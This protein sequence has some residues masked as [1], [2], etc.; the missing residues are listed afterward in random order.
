M[1]ETVTPGFVA[2][3]NQLL[4]SLLSIVALLVAVGL[5]A[6]IMLST[7]TR[8][9]SAILTVLLIAGGTFTLLLLTIGAAMRAATAPEQW[10]AEEDDWRGEMGL[11]PLTDELQTASASTQRIA[12]VLGAVAIV[13]GLGLSVVPAML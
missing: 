12:A 5:G 6:G 11:A 13:L 8:G 1:T 9:I 10:R 4:G 2:R 7:N 3:N